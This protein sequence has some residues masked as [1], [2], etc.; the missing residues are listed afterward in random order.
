[1]CRGEG[2]GGGVR[3]REGGVIGKRSELPPCVKDGRE[4]NPVAIII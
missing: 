2:G 3:E 4:K 1:M